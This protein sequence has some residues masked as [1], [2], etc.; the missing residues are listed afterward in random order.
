MKFVLMKYV[1]WSTGEEQ[2]GCSLKCLHWSISEG[3]KSLS[4]ENISIES[5]ISISGSAVLNMYFGIL[6]LVLLLSIY[7]VQCAPAT[8]CLEVSASSRPS[9]CKKACTR[10]EQC[11]KVNKRCLCDGLCGLSCVNPCQFPFITPCFICSITGR[12]VIAM[13]YAFESFDFTVLCSCS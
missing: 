2:V 11:K 1:F 13:V 9:Y 12:N 3:Q 5:S 6:T 4:T 7:P 10:D 8:R